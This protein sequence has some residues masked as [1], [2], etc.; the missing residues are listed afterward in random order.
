MARI[1]APE[2]SSWIVTCMVLESKSS[3]LGFLIPTAIPIIITINDMKEFT[4]TTC[5]GMTLASI[6]SGLGLELG[7]PIDGTSSNG[8]DVSCAAAD[9]RRVIVIL[10]TVQF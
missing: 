3:S 4:T 10:V 2:L 1:R 5:Y 8:K 9:A 7:R 6:V